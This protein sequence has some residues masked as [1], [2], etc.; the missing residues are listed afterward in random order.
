L[1]SPLRSSYKDYVI[2]QL[3]IAANADMADYWRNELRGCGKFAFPEPPALSA[4]QPPYTSVTP[5]S[6]ELHDSLASAAQ[7]Q[8]VTVKSLCL[9]AYVG[10][11][12]QFSYEND[13]LI[14]LVENGRPVRDDGARILGCFLNT[15]PLRTAIHP[16]M[17]WG[18]L[19]Q[20]V[21]RKQQEIKHYGRMS[22]VQILH[23]AGEQSSQGNPLFDTA[24]NF[25]DFHVYES[26]QPGLFEFM[27]YS[28][29]RTNTML[30]F[31]VS[32][33][34]GE[35]SV[36]MVSSYEQSFTDRILDVYVRVLDCLI[37]RAERMIDTADVMT[38]QEKELLRSFNETGAEYPRDAAITDRF[39]QQVWLHAKR[40]ALIM[41]ERELTYEELGAR[42]DNL[43][44]K[45]LEEGIAPGQTV[46]LIA[47]RSFEM[48]TAI[49][50]I[51][52]IGCAYVPLDPEFPAERLNLIL[53]DSQTEWLLAEDDLAVDGFGGNRISLTRGL[54]VPED[55][56]ADGASARKLAAIPVL[57]DNLA[58]IMYTSGSTGQPKGVRTTHRNIVKTSVNNGFNDIT[59]TDRM[60]QLSNYAFDGS[61]YEIYGALLNGAALVLIPRQDAL[62]AAELAKTLERQR[63]TSAFMTSVVFNTVVDWDIQ[64]LK[65]VRRLFFGGEAASRSHVIKALNYLGERRIAN[66]YG[67]TETTVFA[68]AYPV[69][70]QLLQLGSV[71]I[72]KPVHNTRA[73]VLNQ[74][75]QLQ[76]VGVPGELYI[77]G[78]GLAQGYLGR[79]D[80]TGER[81][82]P[83]PFEAGER[84]YKTGDLARW[85][86]DGNLEYLGRIDQQVKIRG[87][88]V[89]LG[90]IE[91]KLAE[92]ESIREAAVVAERDNQGH[93]Y[94]CAYVVPADAS[95]AP[96]LEWK[97]KLRQ[98]LPEYM[99]PSAF[100]TLEALPL[101]LN[102]KLDRKGLPEVPA[103]RG[104]S[105]SAPAN[106]Y[107][108]KLARIWEEVLHIQNIGME[109]HFFE[110]GGQSLKAML[111]VAKIQKETGYNMSLQDVFQMPTIREMARWM[112]TTRPPAAEHQI[113][114]APQQEV[115]PAS[116][117]QSRL[118]IVQ[119]FEN[120][121][122]SYNM[123]IML[124][125][126]GALDA[127]RLEKALHRLIARHEVLR[128]SFEMRDGELVQRVHLPDSI[129]PSLIRHTIEASPGD[130]DAALSRFAGQ[131]VRP[132]DLAAAPLIRAALL[133][134]APQRHV[135][136][137]DMHHIAADGMSV[138][139]LL[140]D[141]IGLYEERE[142]AELRIQYKDYAVWEDARG[143]SGDDKNEQ[144]WIT[145]FQQAPPV[146]ELPTDHVRPA[147][148]TF[149]G[150]RM[151]VEL[152]P[153]LAARLKTAA[154][155][156]H[157]TLFMIMTGAYHIL[158]AKY[159]GEE[160]IVV[161]T[162]FA[163][164]EVLKEEPVA[165]MFANTLALR[166]HPSAGMKVS[167]YLDSVRKLVLEAFE[168]G[169][170]PL[171]KLINRLSLPF[172]SSRHPLFDTMFVVEDE[173]V[174]RFELPGLSIAAS[175]WDHGTSKFDM[176]W[177][178]TSSDQGIQLAIEYR[179][180]LWQPATMRRMAQH[181]I[182]I[183][184]QMLDRPQLAIG[185][186][187]LLTESEKTQLEA[188]N[189]TD[190]P[191]PRHL[192]VAELF[193]RQCARNGQAE[194][195]V[196]NSRRLTYQ[197]LNEKANQLAWHL[198][199]KGAKPGETVGLL[200]NR[201]PEMIIA[202]LAVVKTGAAYVP[203]DPT[204]PPERMRFMLR[205][206]DAKQVIVAEDYGIPGFGGESIPY[207]EDIWGSLPV[208]NPEGKHRPVPEDALYIMYTS[209]STGMPKGVVTTH[210]N[211]VKTVMNNGYVEIT[212]EDRLLQVSN[213]AFDGATFDIYGAL[214]HGATLV[215]IERDTLLQAA[216]L[217]EVI[218]RENISVLFMTT[219]LFNTLVD[220]GMDCLAGTRKVLFGGEKVSPRHVRK[221]AAALGEDRLLHMYGPTETTVFAT[222]CSVG[223]GEHIPIGRPIHNTRVYV[224]N[225]EGK[226]QPVGVPGELYIGGEGLARSYLGQP[227]LTAARFVD[228]PF[229]PGS[230]MYR[231][232]DLVKWLP[233]GNLEFIERIDR[234][235]KIRGN[236]IELG[237]VERHVRLL[238]GIA[239]AVVA[240]STDERG[241]S[242]LCAYVVPDKSG[243]F[244]SEQLPQSIAG[245]KNELRRQLPEYMVPAVFTRL[246]TLPLTSN[247]K[248]DR[249]ALPEPFLSR[250]DN[251]VPA[252]NAAQARLIRIW[253]DVLGTD[254]I[255]IYDHFF[256]AGGHS[257]KAMLLVG[258]IHQEFNVKL[259]LQ[260]VF[261]LPVLAEMSEWIRRADLQ[262]HHAIAAAPEQSAY[263]LTAAQKQI[264]YAQQFEN[265]GTSYN[266]PML[267]EIAG[268]LDT[269][270]LEAAFTRVL[271]RHEAL[272]TSIHMEAGE[273]F[274]RIHRL[275]ELSWELLRH[276]I[277]TE[278]TEDGRG[279]RDDL[280][281]LTRWMA[282]FVRPFELSQA[283]LVRAALLRRSA[284]RHYLALDMHHI[285]SDGVSAG[286]LYEELLG[287]YQ[288]LPLKPIRLQYKDYAVWE[289]QR[290]ESRQFADSEQFWMEQYSDYTG[291]PELPL[292]RPRPAE[293]SRQGDTFRLALRDDL[294]RR[295]QQAAAS[296]N[297][298]LF[299]LLVSA[300]GTLLSKYTGEEDIVVGTPVAGRDHADIQSTAG[301][302]V[303]TLPLR[304]QPEASLTASEYI[305]RVKERVLAAYEHSGYP[306]ADMIEK[307]R[308]PFRPSRHPLF[309][310]MF[311]LQDLSMAARELRDIAVR[312]LTWQ[313]REAK[314]DMTWAWHREDDRLVADIEYRTDLWDRDTI[315]RMAGHFEHLLEQMLDHGEAKLMELELLTPPEHD[316][317]ASWNDTEAA[318]PLEMTVLSAFEAIVSEQ[319]HHPALRFGD[320]SI[321]YRELNER[322]NRM[323]AHLWRQGI[324]PGDAVGLL[325]ERR[326]EM[327]IA[328][329]AILKTGGVYVPLDSSY[330]EG[331]LGCMLQDCEARWL[332]ADAEKTL[333]NYAGT[334]IALREPQ[335]YAEGAFSSPRAR[336]EASDPVYI[337]Y[338]SGSTGEPK[339]VVTTHGNVVNF[340]R[341]RAF[342]DIG[343][344]DTI[345]QLSNYA[346]D[347]SIFDIFG[348]LL[349][350]ATLVLMTKRQLQ[351][352]SLLAKLLADESI[353]VLFMTTALFNTLADYDMISL[354]G[355]RK[356]LVGGEAASL[357]HILKG[358]DE[359]G[360]GRILNCY[361]PTETT[362]MATM[363]EVDN[364]VRETK[365]VPIGRAVH[366]V[367]IYV[368]NRW[369]KLQPIGVPGELCIAGDGLAAGY[370][371]RPELTEEKFASGVVPGEDR[372]YRTGDLVRWLPDG[373]L[374]YIG[375]I[376]RQVKI[377]GNRIELGEVEEAVASLSMVSEAAIVAHR[378]EQ[379]H[380]MLAAYVVPT[381]NISGATEDFEAAWRTELKRRLPE[382]ML[383][384]VFIVLDAMPL[385]PN[386]K[387]DRQALAKPELVGSASRSAPSSAAE[388]EL[389]A[390]WSELLGAASIGS[391]DHFFELGGHSLKA[392]AL[393]AQISKRWGVKLSLPELFHAAT[394][395]EMARLIEQS[396]AEEYEAIPHA[397]EQATYPVSSPQKRLYLVE[398]F[399]ETGTS[400]NMPVALRLTG[401][402][403][404]NRLELALLGLIRRHE[405]LR[406]SYV[407]MDGEIRQ[408]VH[409]MTEINWRIDRVPMSNLTAG[410]SGDALIHSLIRGFV[411]PFDL[412]AAPLLR[413]ALYT[414]SEGEHLFI[415]DTHHIVSDGMTTGILY[416]DLIKLYQGDALD[417]MRVQFKD[418][419]VWLEN[420]HKEAARLASE[421]YWLD[422]FKE[423]PPV[424]DVLTEGIRPPRRQ[425]AGGTHAFELDPELSR[426]LK[427]L[428]A[429]SNATLFMVLLAAYYVLLSKYTGEKDIVVGTPIAGRDHADAASVAGMFVNTL[430]LRHAPEGRYQVQEWIE[431]VREDTLLAF[432]HGSYP[433]D[434]L[435]EKLRIERDPSRNPLFDTMFVLQDA[436]PETIHLPNLSIE[437]IEW[438]SGMAKFDMTWVVDEDTDLL[439]MTVEYRTDLYS[440]AQITRMTEHYAHVL[441][442]MADRPAM[443]LREVRLITD[444]EANR[445]LHEFNDTDADYPREAT[446]HQLF[447]AQA[448]LRPQHPALRFLNQSITYQELDALAERLADALR[449]QGMR[450]GD[451]IGL[452]A[453][454][455]I[456]MIAAIIGILKAGGAYVPIDPSYPDERVSY[457]LD[458]SGARIVIAASGRSISGYAGLT[459][460]LDGDAWA[461][462][463]R[464]AGAAEPAQAEIPPDPAAMPAYVMYTSGSTGKPKGVITTHR[465]IV[466]TVRNNGFIELGAEDRILQ[467][468]NFAF[469]G[470]T[471]EIFG[472]L[473]N[474]ATL[475]LIAKGD[476]LDMAELAATIERER[477]TSFFATASLFNAMVDY[478]VACLS[479]IRRVFI[480]GETASR[481]HM[482]R[483]YEFLGPRRIANAYGPTETTVFATTYNVDEGLQAMDTVPIGRPIHNTKTYVVDPDGHLLPVGIAGE[484]LIAGE[485]LAQQYLGDPE[486]TNARFVTVP[487][488]GEERAYRTGDRVR[489]LADGK[490]EFISRMD[491]QVKIRGH[492][493]EPG[494]IEARLLEHPGIREAAV[495]ARKEEKGHYLC[496]YLVSPE[497]FNDKELRKY[498]EERLPDYMIPSYFVPIEQLPLTRNGKLDRRSLPEPDIS[499]LQQSY[500]PPGTENEKILAEVW[501]EVLGIKRIGL[502]DNYFVLGGDS[503]KSIQIISKLAKYNRKLQVKHL[504]LHP[505]IAECAP[506]VEYADEHRSADRQSPVTGEL[507]LTPIQRWFF[508]RGFECEEHWNQSM[509]L[510]N[511]QGWDQSTVRK[512]FDRLV[513]HHDALRTRFRR[514]K[515]GI[516]QTMFG[517]E[518]G[519]YYALDVYETDSGDEAAARLESLACELQS[520][521]NIESMLIR[522]GLFKTDQGDHLLII[523]HHLLIDGVSWR[524]LLE[525]FQQIYHSLRAGEQ[526]ALPPKTDS[527]LEWSRQLLKY[528]GE[529]QALRELPYW[530]KL[531][532]RF[533]ELPVRKAEAC[534][535]RNSRTVAIE[536]EEPVTRKLLT[537]AH[538]AYH[539]EVI[540]LLLAALALTYEEDT[541]ICL[542][543]HGREEG[544]VQADV[545]R[546]I[547]WFTSMYP[548]LL[549]LPS[550]E[551][552][553]AVRSV[554]EM[555]RGIPAKGAGY[556]I[557]K[558]L[559]PEF[560]D[561]VD[562][563]R[564]EPD[565]VF[566]YLG[567]FDD[568]TDEDKPALS[569]MP[570]GDLISPLNQM[571]HLEEWNCVVSE[572]R[573]RLTLR[574][575]PQAVDEDTAQRRVTAYASNLLSLIEHCLNREDE[576]FTP[577][578]FTDADLTFDELDDISDIVSKL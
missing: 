399:E 288:G 525:D 320:T 45:L 120:A 428:A 61:T 256:D 217:A 298:T 312:P 359:L 269:G 574:Y 78:E 406:T 233:D 65:H 224:L 483:A 283:P 243:T 305:G 274:Q 528:A 254:G 549:S 552:A 453:D 141:L 537:E 326:P 108:A 467:L 524:I 81:F 84:M 92:M 209:G 499:Q 573:F 90:E 174:G 275:D 149:T 550:R 94:L 258:K 113:E 523:I 8:R 246:E 554:K 142:L 513:E 178:C 348:A 97:S 510:Y 358:L 473:L 336:P 544:M 242:Y 184:T 345:L 569:P 114:P 35:L 319:P 137:L 442:Q 457:M 210:R 208:H 144:Y 536:L 245:W 212:G 292:D 404:A 432:E 306:L 416:R 538:R 66:G 79:P 196:M 231:T 401:N 116:S 450:P 70:K 461:E 206:S 111:L 164:R 37:H 28:F 138:G 105:Y 566:N 512:A 435:I 25:I 270:R 47:E 484:L 381:G 344:G 351:D 76:P 300:Y 330:P 150:S 332:V 466:K 80:L 241:H 152:D 194:A 207:R 436:K 493:I 307:L 420:R 214:L 540:D 407:M 58:Y 567:Q 211:V 21:H 14:G 215:L 39:R 151:T 375:R 529:E 547:G 487:W 276:D 106:A 324:R 67:P 577:S 446:I 541:A 118:Y 291:T 248:V 411:R 394:L 183:V 16:S 329:L 400:Y 191:Y 282:S 441:S 3:A 129:Q 199:A 125:L 24:F 504:M 522:L 556:A 534:T 374:E 63:I 489:W 398:E 236:R 476:V 295:L 9:A 11:L 494:E 451:R 413:A 53:A 153:D 366:N 518:E 143:G 182:H 249:A 481:A 469:D 185:E 187:E 19:V 355:V 156:R 147:V 410:L 155:A 263:P 387:V 253:E 308:I 548:V 422:K 218:R 333:A 189:A 240:A 59:E 503:I 230:L 57:P 440:A 135:L 443:L 386:G 576:Q 93:S 166:T 365:R 190:M 303:N 180:N 471:F 62:N 530:R 373:N 197:S 278:T 290:K 337:M 393:V 477:I 507:P 439:R 342:V 460:P 455:S 331:R 40:P 289:H 60:L 492:R 41:G 132:F 49:F 124:K 101:T 380:S 568:S 235:V 501:S 251:Y 244:P 229:R 564:E 154:A 127:A 520:A 75:G 506:Y 313:G 294:F 479:S 213:Y 2:E 445:I 304:L 418:Y 423:A 126:D 571:S 134:L 511:R 502:E 68:A 297:S 562:I 559:T 237:E 281:L 376:D 515:E 475:V 409:A 488:L 316:L 88:R 234:Q 87:N 99:V 459:I 395:G 252:E 198:I 17:S 32:V 371:G 273:L 424:I 315:E 340:C 575:H 169:A 384:S 285:V 343:P 514:E 388:K 561:E 491:D 257:L 193:E 136:L 163:C 565:I 268:A 15:V 119:Q 98:A 299:I 36:K 186:L 22:L 195:V 508:E 478:N 179:S 356:L 172:D 226:R 10:T 546:T 419:A 463:V 464:A 52:R 165:G 438:H 7:H 465:N 560:R 171:Q 397:P 533:S 131:F 38:R 128:T 29:E 389:A 158:L 30:D 310:T 159:S 107:E 277:G 519:P 139:I 83:C 69:D 259:S 86:P 18:E 328:I 167:E 31:S 110:I 334:V 173:G 500:V 531:H 123:P 383:P 115:Y 219:A 314:F 286:V 431:R 261:H 417:A 201:S 161:G 71:P 412:S 34:L 162:P 430:A 73:Y 449:F 335:I 379:G 521:L 56:A 517:L 317:L 364:R 542:E 293:R 390:L 188:W 238:P 368:L 433:L 425:F 228:D 267:F 470:S 271:A 247:G 202:I 264:Y 385:T 287:L 20:A 341:N 361:G 50:A 553:D 130:E 200:M 539:T 6:P 415:M 370:L 301:M 346:F 339:G 367:R 48:I 51:L 205:D 354:Q 46:G 222:S 232:G 145:R 100:I 452:L 490:L 96:V 551:L 221:A 309:D 95:A 176:T 505:T 223:F 498:L 338:T 557:L 296:Y 372:I 495:L 12:Y 44:C 369:D 458:H 545:T 121:G 148:R 103:Q 382:Y 496:A 321:S 168:H 427:D 177:V 85:L 133:R 146:V 220:L 403:D 402:A 378:D 362:V 279:F 262:I 117:I 280:P 572:G 497:G 284:N 405:A 563:L 266:M 160:D 1:L 421:R 349:N 216:E 77:A 122:T 170:F 89:E 426:K 360:E 532:K 203:L 112:M 82:V 377:R 543:G 444:E 456:E 447:E 23:A 272:R 311:V 350:G 322:A 5:L 140:D 33:T 109:A 363:Y 227:E 27:P 323:A 472:A 64:C 429:Q 570:M 474:G 4:G 250:E 42:V 482:L 55:G 454:R 318:Y 558:Y 91:N 204:F 535:Y 486:L 54:C 352:V 392:M 74:A 265:A 485:G 104:D 26:V 225:K 468:S 239:E 437:P 181:Y 578:D 72:G 260:D 43:A 434:E 327:I 325:A 353:T 391:Q 175:E 527:Y 396:A 408:R 157:D 555:L 462:C 13:I 509:M 480:G 302:F 448:A 516:V 192:S 347:G 357:K 526:P 102:G 414:L 255:G